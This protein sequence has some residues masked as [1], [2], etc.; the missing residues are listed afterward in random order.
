MLV[1]QKQNPL[2]PREG[3]VEGSGA[4][5]EVQTSP[6]RSPQKALMAAVEFM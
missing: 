1:G 6:P 3:P 4:L 5:E 2:A